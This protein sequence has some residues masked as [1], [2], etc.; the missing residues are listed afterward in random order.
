MKPTNLYKNYEWGPDCNP[1]PHPNTHA[2]IQTFVFPY[3]FVCANTHYNIEYVT[4]DITL[5][6]IKSSLETGDKK[7]LWFCDSILFCTLWRNF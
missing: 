7:C 6:E 3:I 2:H 4:D 1:H 5:Q